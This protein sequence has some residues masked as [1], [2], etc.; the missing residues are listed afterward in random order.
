MGRKHRLTNPRKN[1]ERNLYAARQLQL[2]VAIPLNSV[3]IGI[4]EHVVSIPRS[5]VTSSPVTELCWLQTRLHESGMLPQGWVDA[6]QHIVPSGN[7]EL[8]LCKPRSCQPNRN[9]TIGFTLRVEPDFRWKLF[10]SSEEVHS[11]PFLASVP[12]HLNT[13]SQIVSLL[14]AL[15][16]AKICEGN[17][18]AKFHVLSGWIK[19]VFMDPS[20]SALCTIILCMHV[21]EMLVR[22]LR[23]GTQATAKWD[24][25]TLPYP[26]IR[27]RAC[28]MLLTEDASAERCK[29]CGE[30]RKVLR[31]HLSRQKNAVDNTVSRTDPTSHVNIRYLQT[32]EMET[33]IKL[34]HDTTR[35]LSKKIG[36]LEAKIDA[37]AEKAGVV[38]DEGMHRDITAIMK[39]ESAKVASKYPANSFQHQFWEQQLKAASCK[40][41]RGMRWHPLMIRWCLYLRHKSSSAYETL[42]DSG[43]IVLPSQRTLRDYTHHISARIGF[44]HEI[45]QQLMNAANIHSCE[46]WQ[47]CVALIFDEMH[48]REDL[49]Y[50]KHSGALIGFANLGEINS[51]LLEFERSLEVSQS[52]T[53]PLANSMTVFMVRGLF[54]RL[55]FPYA[56]FPSIKVSG[57]LLF[58]PFWEAVERLERC[59][60][61]VLAATADGASV[62][63]KLF[64]LLRDG[65]VFHKVVNPFAPDCRDIFF[66]SD[67]PH[68]IKTARNCMTSTA[69]NMTVRFEYHIGSSDLCFSLSFSTVVQWQEHKVAA[70]GGPIPQKQWC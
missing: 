60:L 59:Q 68:L 23:A 63:R 46:E 53:E 11:C 28:C 49:V 17:P 4:S 20:G 36:R 43:L 41:A 55:Q 52:F 9:V 31:A 10:L 3:S 54:T 30:Y 44:S 32:P 16:S 6:S 7:I 56:Q 1:S 39:S 13:V 66:F 51:H 47:K 14:T 21:Y 2:R 22:L 8:V 25:N 50:D 48:I 37:A 18:D 15:D 69:R 42:R 35:T 62:N 61:K 65:K 29:D 5:I 45:D 40:N 38:V 70:C 33:R 64:K 67:P 19:G 24:E 58:E 12:G 27:H 57:D 34:L 26:T